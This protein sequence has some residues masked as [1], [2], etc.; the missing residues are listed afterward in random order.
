M[1]TE[2]T[3]QGGFSAFVNQKILPPI[4]KFVN[5]KAVKAIQDGMVYSLPFIIIGSIFLIM[6]N[7]PIPAV[8]QALSDSGWSAFFSQ[9]YTASFGMI[10]VWSVVGIAY[11]YVKNEKVEPLPAALTALSA[12]LLLQFMQVDSPLK[13][14]EASGI[15]NAAGKV[16][17]SGSAVAQNIDKLPHALQTFLASPVTNVLNITWFGG[18]GMV[19]AIIIGLLVGWSYSAM[20]KKGWKIKLP[21]QVPSSVS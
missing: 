17:L 11:V 1:S 10:S 13:A 3:K 12:F 2:T 14:A 20:M 19:A 15:S 18:Q 9:A 21:E 7:F 8:S 5:T 16:V 4:M 6:S